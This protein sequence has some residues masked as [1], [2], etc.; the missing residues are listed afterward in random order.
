MDACWKQK[1][2]SEFCDAVGAAAY[3]VDHYEWDTL[4]AHGQPEVGQSKCD[5]ANATVD[6]IRT[7]AQEM[8]SISQAQSSYDPALAV[9][10][11][12]A[13]HTIQDNCAHSGMPNPE[14]AWFSLSDSCADTNDSPDV[15]PGAVACAEQETALAFDTFVKAIQ[16]P[17][18][19]PPPDHDTNNNPN[20]QFWPSRGGVCDFLKSATTWDGTDRRWN[21]QVVVPAVQDQLYKNLLVDPN[22][23]SNDVCAGGEAA[24]EPL[25]PVPNLDTSHPTEWCTTISLYCAGK[26][27]GVDEAPPWEPK[28]SSSGPAETSESSGCNLANHRGSSPLWLFGALTA[29]LGLARRRVRS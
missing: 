24:L 21:N 6:R 14:H 25:A 13:L 17:T 20:P 18:P 1:L 5:A 16:V 28:P 27:D 10:L 12:R 19:P 9:A 29:L 23:P 4:A 11:G 2:P 3:N 15:Q 7:L 8:R 22:A 26:A